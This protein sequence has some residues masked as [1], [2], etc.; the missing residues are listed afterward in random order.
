MSAT[1]A[2]PSEWLRL[3]EGADADARA[4]ELLEPLLAS[5]P[6]PPL[7]VRDLGGG[8]GAMGRWLAGR[9]P[10]PQ[11]WI[12]HDLAPGP[13]A[14]DA[15]P[16]GGSVTVVRGDIGGIGVAE[17]APTALVTASALLDLL[18]AAEV[19][20]LAE[21]CAGAACPALLTL[22]VTGHVAFDPAD[23]LDAVFA[24]AFNDHQ[25]RRGLLGP[26]APGVAAA[27]FERLGVT[28]HRSP[29]PWRLGPEQAALAGR[30]LQG[31]VAA[32]VE[33]VPDLALVA[34]AYL[35]RRRGARVVVGHEDL[36]ALPG[37]KS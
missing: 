24:D 11:H 19:T 5:L 29:S 26:D 23:P 21:V 8:D 25:R 6:E 36:L 7:V 18:T 31:W 27:A 15:L 13:H 3:R 2:Y 9:L 10:G 16:G 1:T 37:G 17:L 34:D 14:G 4:V 20:R 32:A 30:W 33:Q 12:V 35:D 22:S 28:V